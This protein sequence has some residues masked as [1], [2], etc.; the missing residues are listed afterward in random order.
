MSKKKPKKQKKD[1]FKELVDMMQK[2]T[3]YPESMGKGQV[4]GNDVA[5][6]RDILNN[7]DN[8]SV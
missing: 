4:K 6:I 2:K 5:R 3:R 8:N 1:P 7:E